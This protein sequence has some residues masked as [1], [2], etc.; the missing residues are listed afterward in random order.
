[1]GTF[2]I[3]VVEWTN[4]DQALDAIANNPTALLIGYVMSARDVKLFYTQTAIAMII[5]RLHRVVEMLGPYRPIYTHIGLG[6]VIQKGEVWQPTDPKHS[7]GRTPEES[8]DGGG[9]YTNP[10]ALNI[11]PPTMGWNAGN[12]SYS[13]RVLPASGTLYIPQDQVPYS[14]MRR[15]FKYNHLLTALGLELMETLQAVGA[16]FTADASGN[17]T[18]DLKYTGESNH[19]AQIAQLQLLFGSMF[20]SVRGATNAGDFEADPTSTAEGLKDMLGLLFNSG[21][22]HID[23]GVLTHV[24]GG[25]TGARLSQNI[26][27]SGIR[28]RGQ[29]VS[30]A[31][32]MGE[33]IQKFIVF[34]AACTAM[35]G[36]FSM[37]LYDCHW[38]Y[39]GSP[40]PEYVI[41][42]LQ[43]NY[44]ADVAFDGGGTGSEYT[45]I[46]SRLNPGEILQRVP[47][48]MQHQTS[49]P[50]TYLGI[51]DPLPYGGV[52]DIRFHGDK[53]MTTIEERE[54]T[55]TPIIEADANVM[56]TMRNGR[57]V[58]IAVLPRP[59][60]YTPGVSP[61]GV[62]ASTMLDNS[63]V[64]GSYYFQYQTGPLFMDTPVRP[65]TRPRA[66]RAF[67]DIEMD[68]LT[69]GRVFAGQTPEEQSASATL[70]NR[71]SISADQNPQMGDNADTNHSTGGPA[72][73]G[74]ALGSEEVV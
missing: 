20:G 7:K 68:P 48:L 42:Q 59:S 50:N 51:R 70:M 16:N 18:N 53:P 65:G 67:G 66:F 26:G 72:L 56:A 17:L 29:A 28:Y 30:P 61:L 39:S 57:A 45:L 69:Q 9:E 2:P 4:E 19:G 62:M 47:C 6:H 31:T 74:S 23:P 38:L 25:Y 3:R 22:V 5:R 41:E 58:N 32:L 35:R 71:R 64:G 55:F 33:F 43:L 14:M 10:G 34:A 1:V 49:N 27:G 12:V 54:Y 36:L 46:P 40:K 73:I 37:P 11:C 8:A 44:R 63:T 13:N 52:Q 60:T 24:D 21:H 15:G